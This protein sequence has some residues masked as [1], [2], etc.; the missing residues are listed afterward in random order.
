MFPLF[1]QPGFMMNIILGLLIPKTHYAITSALEKLNQPIKEDSKFNSLKCH[2]AIFNN[3]D[4]LIDKRLL[5]YQMKTDPT[6][7]GFCMG[8]FAPIFEKDNL[9][10]FSAGENKEKLLEIIVPSSE[11]MQ[12]GLCTYK[13]IMKNLVNKIDVII[14]QDLPKTIFSYQGMVFIDEKLILHKENLAEFYFLILKE[15]A[16][17]FLFTR[18]KWH[19]ETWIFSGLPYYM[20]TIFFEQIADIDNITQ[21]LPFNEIMTF[22]SYLKQKAVYLELV[23]LSQPLYKNIANNYEKF[24]LQDSILCYKSLYFF[25]Q[26]FKAR[27]K[28]PLSDI[29]LK[30]SHYITNKELIE[31]IKEFENNTLDEFLEDW[32]TVKGINEIEIE[33]RGSSAKATTLKEFIIVQKEFG[34]EENCCLKTHYTDVLLLNQSCRNQFSLEIT[35]K[36]QKETLFNEL[37]GKYLPK[38][39][40]IDSDDSAYFRFKL[41]EKSLQFLME[42]L[43]KIDNA[44]TRLNLYFCFYYEML[45]GKFNQ[46]AFLDIVLKHLEKENSYIVLKYILNLCQP[47]LFMGFE[48]EKEIEYSEK[49][50]F[51]IL[52]LIEQGKF[53]N[54]L[55]KYITKFAF[56]PNST[57]LLES[58]FN[59]KH[60][61]LIRYY[62]SFSEN[63]K[64]KLLARISAC[65]SISSEKRAK[66]QENFIKSIE[67]NELLKEKARIVFMAASPLEEDKNKIWFI[68]CEN[69]KNIK[70]SIL[71]KAFRAFLQEGQYILNQM[72]AEKFFEELPLIVNKHDEE[73][74]L[75]FAKSLFPRKVLNGDYI[76]KIGEVLGKI[77]EEKEP[78]IAKF[79]KEKLVVIKKMK[80]IAEKTG[81][82]EN[83]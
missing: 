49:F 45:D 83:I 81:G 59:E 75:E 55:Y 37:E 31:L 9:R 71:K 62:K 17:Q 70:L 52:K 10:F 43:H 46:L 4:D 39:V 66:Y 76:A 20:A 82:E 5:L 27:G 19:D 57:A 61:S 25:K 24:K 15:L 21:N 54:L 34:K 73:Y 65:E 41:D 79:L 29:F 68:F 53:A 32:L 28:K 7:L 40:L 56:I 1:D 16:K 2:E 36:K 14:L 42:N 13:K 60:T 12:L 69:V 3:I 44:K 80:E 26:L 72:F 6:C 78:R 50:L 35:I 67:K 30:M 58:I 63:S 51:L 8:E 74:A 38:A 33:L 64:M 11:I 47:L 48:K 22:I 23:G 77:D 18:S